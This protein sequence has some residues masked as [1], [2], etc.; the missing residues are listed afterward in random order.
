M[1]EAEV[2]EILAGTIDE[3]LVL[4]T[5]TTACDDLDR[6]VNLTHLHRQLTHEAFISLDTHLPHFVVDLPILHVVWFRMAVG[7]TYLTP[8]AC[9]RLV[10]VSE[11]VKRLLNDLFSFRIRT[12]EMDR[13]H[14]YRLCIDLAAELDE[15]VCSEAVLVI[16]HPHPVR[17]SVSFLLRSDTPFPVI[18]S[19]IAAAWP[20]QTCRME[21]LY[22]LKD[23]RTETAES[24]TCSCRKRNLIDLY[25]SV[26]DCDSKVSVTA[27]LSCRKSDV[28]LLPLIARYADVLL[29]DEAVSPLQT[30]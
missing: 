1:M 24:L 6:R 12:L 30:Y 13:N 2:V 3:S 10:A 29:D 19:Y 16:I 21:I 22:S 15:L 14:D 17:P 26:L 23:V 27:V 9:S 11:P 28:E 18:L 25:G 8:L 20:A 7:G 4:A 5:E